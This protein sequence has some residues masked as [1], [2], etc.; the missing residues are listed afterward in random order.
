[1]DKTDN[2]ASRLIAIYEKA[3]SVQTQ[4]PNI[5]ARAGWAYVFEIPTDGQNLTVSNEIELIHRLIQLIKLVDETEQALLSIEGI[6]HERYLTPF[7]A[8]RQ[9]ISLTT[10]SQA[11][12]PH[13]V[14]D[15]H[16]VILGFCEEKLAEYHLEPKIEEE[17]I[18][19]I[20]DEINNLYEEVRASSLHENLK[21]IILEQLEHIRRAIHE[22]RIRGAERLREELV[23]I[24]GNYVL[25]REFIE[26]A[27]DNPEVGKYKSLLSNFASMVAFASHTTKLIEAAAHYLPHLLPGS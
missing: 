12:Q 6:N 10:L 17:Q 13:A 26:Q 18:K 7:P 3:R 22:Y 27:N 24:I 14:T 21:R 8:I 15:T 5:P 1:M 4:N 2:P 16:M 19:N 20:L 9:T 23:T 25:N 11:F